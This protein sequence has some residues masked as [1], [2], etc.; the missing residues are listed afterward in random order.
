MKPFT[1]SVGINALNRH[2]IC[3]FDRRLVWPKI[4]TKW[5]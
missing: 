5:K 1:R 3:K 2:I 4:T